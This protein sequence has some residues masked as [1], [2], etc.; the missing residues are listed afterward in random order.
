MLKTGRYLYV[1]FSCQQ[2]IEKTLKALV[3]AKTKELPPRI[4]NLLKLAEIIGVE[5]NEEDKL[6]LEK[7][8][9][10]YLETRYPEELIK[11]SRQV[12]RNLAKK[13]FDKTKEIVRWL[14]QK[15]K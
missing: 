13:Y 3:T 14:R 15:I 4:H 8:S 7:M 6:F 12:K 9:Y 10:Y 1:L 5:L 11:I 2:A